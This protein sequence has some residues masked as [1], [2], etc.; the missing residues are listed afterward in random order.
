MD[1]PSRGMLHSAD[2]QS[3]TPL[4]LNSQALSSLPHPTL[5]FS[6]SARH[7]PWV[8]VTYLCSSACCS[9]LSHSQALSSLPH[10][11]LSLNPPDASRFS[12]GHVL[13]DFI[14]SPLAHSLSLSRSLHITSGQRTHWASLPHSLSL[15]GHRSPVP[16]AV[17]ALSLTVSGDFPSSSF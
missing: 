6:R 7:I 13:I 12:D 15:T 8:P 10:P 1:E 2:S 9:T 17:S 5:S 11:T 3:R 4:T 14:V 16:L